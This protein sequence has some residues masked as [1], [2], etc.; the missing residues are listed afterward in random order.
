MGNVREKCNGMAS[1]LKQLQRMIGT[2]IK[3]NEAEMYILRM[4]E[5]SLQ[6]YFHILKIE[7]SYG[8]F[9]VCKIFLECMNQMTQ[10]SDTIS[11]KK[12]KYQD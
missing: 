6:I 11:K 5:N 3:T 12:R 9:I 8:S 7:Y 2:R 4:T 10:P 1:W